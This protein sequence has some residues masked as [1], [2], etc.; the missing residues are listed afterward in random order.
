MDTNDKKSNFIKELTPEEMKVNRKFIDDY[1]RRE[2]GR[3]ITPENPLTGEIL[4]QIARETTA[5]ESPKASGP[6]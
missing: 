4:K 1:N 3:G 2:M 5:D 6:K